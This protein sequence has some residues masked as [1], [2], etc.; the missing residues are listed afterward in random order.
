MD[1]AESYFILTRPG[2]GIYK[3]KGSRFLGYAF[4]LPSPED[5]KPLFDDLRSRHPKARHHCF[6]YRWG[7]EG[8]HFRTSDDAE[9]SGTAGRPILGQIDRRRLTDC[10]VIVVRYFGGSLLGVPGLIHAYQ[11]AASEAL[12]QAGIEEKWRAETLILRIPYTLLSRIEH[13]LRKLDIRILDQDYQENVQWKIEIRPSRISALLDFLSE[14]H[15][16]EYS[17]LDPDSPYAPR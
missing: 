1:K 9:P 11:S 10:L 6:A 4:P 2:E 3:E 8:H 16:V 13:E 12:D 7:T 14:L 17:F 5:F 15:A